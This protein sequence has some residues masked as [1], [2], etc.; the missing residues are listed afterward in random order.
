[1]EPARESAREEGCPHV[2]EDFDQTLKVVADSAHSLLHT[3]LAEAATGL[4]NEHPRF[5]SLG[6]MGRNCLRLGVGLA[7][8]QS[9]WMGRLIITE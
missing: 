4:Q 3:A 1:M 8:R 9:R 6:E 7:Q 5:T 2:I